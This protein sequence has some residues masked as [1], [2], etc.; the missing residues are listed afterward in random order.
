MALLFCAIGRISCAMK[1]YS[2]AK[3][4]HFVG[5][6]PYW[7]RLREI[8]SQNEAAIIV[9]YGRRRVGKTELVEQFFRERLLLKFEGLQPDRSTIRRGSA[10]EKQRQI[11]EC[12]MRLGDYLERPAEYLRMRIERWRDFFGLLVPLLEKDPVVLYLDELQWLANYGDELLS[13]LKPWWDDVL[14]HN[15]RLRIVISGSSPAFIVNQFLASSAMYNRSNHMMKLEPF[16]LAEIHQFLGKGHREAMLAAIAVGGIPEYLKQLTS[17]PSVYVDLC[18]KSFRPGGFFRVEKDRVFVSSMAANPHY[19]GI[20]SYL[21]RQGSATRGEI[22]KALTKKA[23]P[24]AGSM[25]KG[26]KKKTARLPGGRFSAMLRDLVE[27][28]FV[29]R[30]LPITTKI[31]RAAASRRPAEPRSARYAICDEYLEFYYR[32]IDRLAE[33]IDSGLYQTNPVQAM[34]RS[35]FSTLMGFS[36]ERWCRKN[37]HLI[38]RRLGFGGVVRYNHGLWHQ[39]DSVQIDLMYI[40]KDSVL[41][42]CEIKFNNESTLTRDVIRDV[43][44]K[45]DIFMAAKP[46]YATYTVET[47][48]ISTEPAPSAIRD[49]GYFTYLVTSQELLAVANGTYNS[50]P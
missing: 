17:G 13:E 6:Q 22:Y 44:K 14:R 16:D 43:Q 12:L 11:H 31:A 39:K 7:Q 45:I 15:P 27:L 32:F 33:D 35:D 21:A 8:D 41:I 9:V 30:N 36:F 19:E 18:A 50:H 25:Q 38:A 29:A 37:A 4:P 48:L 2:A 1:Y 40:R 10:Q 28:D 24:R 26:L 3:N 20:I 5:R 23:S 49:E 47:A 46:K 34:N 42:I